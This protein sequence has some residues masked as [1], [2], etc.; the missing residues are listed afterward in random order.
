MPT[1]SSRPALI[2]DLPAIVGLLA[3][4]VLGQQREN[5]GLAAQNI[6]D[7]VCSNNVDLEIWRKFP[8]VPKHRG[9]QM[10][11]RHIR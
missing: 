1:V 7:V 3:E 2:D 9:Q 5:I 4:D 6:S 10:S 8:D 11:G